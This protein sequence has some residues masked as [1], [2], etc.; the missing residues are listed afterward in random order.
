MRETGRAVST[1]RVVVGAQVVSAILLILWAIG[2]GPSLLLRDEY[3]LTDGV[4]FLVRA[5]SILG[6]LGGVCAFFVSTFA[7]ARRMK[8]LSVALAALWWCAT[9]SVGTRLAIAFVLIAIVMLILRFVNHRVVGAAVEAVIL[10]PFLVYLVLVTSVATSFVRGFPHGVLRITSFLAE[11]NTP[12][13]LDFPTWV[14]PIKG[15]VSSIVAAVPL[16]E[17]SAGRAPDAAVLWGNL[18]P[19]PS[20]LLDIDSYAVER[21]WPYFWVPLSFV[22]EW[23]G[24]LG[25]LALVALL[26]LVTFVAG[27]GCVFLQRNGSV[28]GVLLV[29]VLT[30]ALSFVVIQYP[31]R[32]SGRMISFIFFLPIAIV[33]LGTIGKWLRGTRDGARAR[34]GLPQ[35]QS[36]GERELSSGL[37]AIDRP[38]KVLC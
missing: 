25:P 14:R 3:L 16:T 19:L 6:P 32:T 33:A 21:F 23:Y 29:L 8:L 34:F 2:Q 27:L 9:V 22:G 1:S 4:D 36:V 24:A 13:L 26:G 12:T 17:Q 28:V 35:M 5:V 38:Q 10:L 11:A 7:T 15:F 30:V 37:D 18:N 20:S 31:S